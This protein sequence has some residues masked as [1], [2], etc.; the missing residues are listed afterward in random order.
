M[1][2]ISIEVVYALPDEP[3]VVELRLP[4]GTTAAQAIERSGLIDRHPEIGDGCRQIGI[5]GRSCDGAT[6]LA[7]GDRV[8]IYRP[9]SEDVKA[10]RR[11][12]VA[13]TRRK[14]AATS[15]KNKGPA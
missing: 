8:E 2:E 13:A 1:S 5:F 12:R 15:A 7:D 9:L 3:F 4:V 14:R 6:V 10:R 11:D